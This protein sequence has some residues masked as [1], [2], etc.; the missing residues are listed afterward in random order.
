MAKKASKSSRF[1]VDLGSL[2]LTAAQK[3]AIAGSIGDAAMRELARI[4]NGGLV[5]SKIPQKWE[6]QGII[7]R[8][9]R[10]LGFDQAALNKEL[11]ALNAQFGG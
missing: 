1:V 8:P 3:A 9:I 7:A 10:D 6:W 5:V 2:P 4:D 11:A